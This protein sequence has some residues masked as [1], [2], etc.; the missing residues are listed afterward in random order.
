MTESTGIHM[1]SIDDNDYSD[2]RRESHV[3]EDEAS[4]AMQIEKEQEAHSDQQ[5]SNE[6]MI[7]EPI[8][9][10]ARN[11]NGLQPSPKRFY[12]TIWRGMARRILAGK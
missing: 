9:R 6:A 10:F 1:D 2:G 3:C 4:C 7:T 11:D 12:R 5:T 8:R